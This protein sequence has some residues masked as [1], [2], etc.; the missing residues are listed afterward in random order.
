MEFFSDYIYSP[1]LSWDEVYGSCLENILTVTCL[2]N[3][4][5]LRYC[6]VTTKY[7]EQMNAAVP[8][9]SAQQNINTLKCLDIS[10]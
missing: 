8:R 1:A 5:A 7:V 10:P 3:M 2:D 4:V 6:T 9:F